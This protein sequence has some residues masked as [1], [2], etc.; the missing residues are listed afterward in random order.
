MRERFSSFFSRLFFIFVNHFKTISNRI[1]AFVCDA[2]RQ[3]GINNPSM[4]IDFFFIFMQHIPWIVTY[5]Q[6]LCIVELSIIVMENVE[7]VE[8]VIISCSKIFLVNLFSILPICT[9]W[10]SMWTFRAW[11]MQWE[12]RVLH[13][14]LNCHLFQKKHAWAYTIHAYISNW[15]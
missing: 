3:I 11:Q 9:P 7:N 4:T 12:L 14:I 8:N 6:F 2:K 10:N 13:T 1:F 15:H 5:I